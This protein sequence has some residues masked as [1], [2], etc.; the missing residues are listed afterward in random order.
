LLLTMLMPSSLLCLR[1]LSC[2]FIVSLLRQMSIALDNVS[3][4]SCKSFFWVALS[5]IQSTKRSW[6]RE[7][8]KQA[9]KLQVCASFLSV[10]TYLSIDSSSLFCRLLKMKCLYV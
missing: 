8:C 7:S 6:M 4:G 1:L 10:V 9:Q 3:F 5:F 2:F